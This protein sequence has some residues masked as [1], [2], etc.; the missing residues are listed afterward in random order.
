MAADDINNYRPVANIPFIGK[1]VERVVANQL[2][3]LLEETGA[4]DPF[5]SVFRPHRGTETALVTLQD[6]LLREANRGKVSLLVL[7]NLS[8]AFDITDTTF[9]TPGTLLGRLSG[10]GVD[11]QALPWLRSFLE[12]R[13][14]R[15]QLAEMLSAP[16]TLNCGVL[17]GSVISPM[18]FNIY[19]RLLGD[20]IRSL[21]LR[22]T[23]TQMTPIS[24]YPSV[25]LQW[26]L[27]CPL[28]ATWMWWWDG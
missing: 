20:V 10:L 3:A 9:D 15:V 21:E 23:N 7:L 14:Q 24:I 22:V 1:L 16:L 11:A 27:S 2:H 25:L 13:P 12:D 4:L 6:D 17:Q 5:Q 18:L 8:V 26:T 19:M 28:S